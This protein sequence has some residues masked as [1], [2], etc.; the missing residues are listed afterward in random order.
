MMHLLVAMLLA[1]PLTHPEINVAIRESRNATPVTDKDLRPSRPPDCK[2]DEDTQRAV[3][4]VRNGESGDC[5]VR[6]V[7]AFNRH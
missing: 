3:S 5:W 2:T 7:T 6:D 1:P 4:Q